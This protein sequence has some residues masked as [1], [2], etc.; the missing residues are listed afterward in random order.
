MFI[1]SKFNILRL[2]CDICRS[3]EKCSD[4][5]HIPDPAPKKKFL[6]KKFTPT[7]KKPIF[8]A[9]RKNFLYFPEKI[10]YTCPKK[11]KFSK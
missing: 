4:L 5:A 2:N 7:Q 1:L 9:R 6:P 3:S 10:S 11:L 8:H